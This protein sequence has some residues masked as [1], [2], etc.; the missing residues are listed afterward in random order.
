M[1]E[2]DD[3]N[4]DKYEYNTQKKYGKDKDGVMIQYRDDAS[5]RRSDRG[6]E[7]DGF[8]DEEVERRESRRENDSYHR[9]KGSAWE[10]AR[11]NKGKQNSNSNQHKEKEKNRERKMYR[12]DDEEWEDAGSNSLNKSR[13]QR[14]TQENRNER[15]RERDR[16]VIASAMSSP[17]P[18][19][20]P[21]NLSDMKAF[22][23]C[24]IPKGASI[25]QCYIRRNKSGTNKLFPVYS[26]YLKDGDRFLMNS[27]K[28]T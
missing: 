25:V 22:L 20:A 9:D 27:K 1:D 12:D 10:D 14:G 26:L 6:F 8:D 5:N 7:N 2:V 23:T 24:P 21:L 13:L 19:I 28:K 11:D 4:L 15:V 18:V 17:T 3:D 16:L